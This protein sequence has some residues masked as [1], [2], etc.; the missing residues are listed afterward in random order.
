MNYYNGLYTKQ[1]KSFKK[2]DCR[3]HGEGV[4]VV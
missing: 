1:L 2:V 3:R 4:S